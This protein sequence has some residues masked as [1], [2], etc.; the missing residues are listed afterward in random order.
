MFFPEASPFL[1]FHSSRPSESKN[2]NVNASL[3]IGID[4]GQIRNAALLNSYGEILQYDRAQ[5]IPV[6]LEAKELADVYSML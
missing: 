6:F 5:N 3:G 2:A 4:L 1:Y